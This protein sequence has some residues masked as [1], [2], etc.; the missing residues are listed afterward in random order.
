MLALT[1]EPSGIREKV[2]DM[3]SRKGTASFLKAYLQNAIT[4]TEKQNLEVP[5]T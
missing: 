5:L 3:G 4:S 2:P 1:W